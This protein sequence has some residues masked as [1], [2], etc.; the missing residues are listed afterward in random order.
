MHTS[1]FALGMHRHLQASYSLNA[2]LSTC[3]PQNWV[4]LA[5]VGLVI[6]TLDLK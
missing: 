2:L 3:R 4:I 1:R 5:V 6:R